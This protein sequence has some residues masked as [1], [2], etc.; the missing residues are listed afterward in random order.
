MTTTIRVHFEGS[1]YQ[2]TA[3]RW[4]IPN[5]DHPFKS[6]P[7]DATALIV[8]Q[9]RSLFF[10]DQFDK[11][12]QAITLDAAKTWGAD[13]DDT[14]LFFARARTTTSGF[15]LRLVL[16]AD[17]FIRHKNSK[18]FQAFSRLVRDAQF[19]SA[20]LDEIEGLIV[21]IHYGM[22]LMD[23]G[24]WAGKVL[25]SITQWCGISW[26]ELSY[27]RMNTEANRI[28]VGRTFEALHDS[29]VDYGGLSGFD[30]FRHVIIDISAPG[31]TRD[32]LL[33]GK[34]PCYITGFSEAHISHQCMR[35]VP[36]LPLGSYLPAKEVRCEEI[37]HVL[38]LL[39]FMKRADTRVSASAALEWH[40]KYSELYPDADN[41]EVL[42]AQRARLYPDVPSVYEGQ[43]TVSFEGDDEYPKAIIQRIATVD[44]G[45][46]QEQTPDQ[47]LDHAGTERLFEP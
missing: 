38:V 27:T 16:N 8:P 13:D 1:P 41:L 21:P 29:G 15:C 30:I 5:H 32:D 36:V 11:R 46:E 4:N 2:Y 22:W 26:N 23:T 47:P 18:R 12:P 43:L 9:T 10:N 17:K 34:A 40:D 3:K 33:N 28:L 44:S 7:A 19:H 24:D 42:M 25:F 37:S 31:L 20:H 35:R 6:M 14:G 45:G 39:D